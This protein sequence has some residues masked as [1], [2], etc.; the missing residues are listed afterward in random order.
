MQ[1]LHCRGHVLTSSSYM[2]SHDW[3]VEAYRLVPVFFLPAVVAMLCDDFMWL[4]CTSF[5]LCEHYRYTRVERKCFALLPTDLCSH[6]LSVCQPLRKSYTQR[7]HN[8]IRAVA[9]KIPHHRYHHHHHHHHHHVIMSTPSVVVH[10]V[11]NQFSRLQWGDTDQFAF[12]R[13]RVSHRSHDHR[14]CAS[15]LAFPS[16]SSRPMRLSRST[17]PRGALACCVVS[18]FQECCD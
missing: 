7:R 5:F 10:R 18:S 3:M 11:H 1:I 9:S 16:R 12:L 13:C 17:R 14:V 8:T 6:R 4:I 2:Y 15:S